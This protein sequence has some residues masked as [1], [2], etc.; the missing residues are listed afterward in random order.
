MVSHCS[1][2]RQRPRAKPIKQICSTTKNYTKLKYSYN[3]NVAYQQL[4]QSSIFCRN[5]TELR[6]NACY[7]P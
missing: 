4:A 6:K 2:C 5:S 3:L 7:T 1:C